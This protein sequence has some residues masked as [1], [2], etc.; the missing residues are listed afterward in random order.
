MFLIL[1]AR[2]LHHGQ[3]MKAW[4]AERATRMEVFYLSRY[5]PV[6]NPQECLN[7]DLKQ[8]MGKPVPVSAKACPM[9]RKTPSTAAARATGGRGRGEKAGQPGGGSI[10]RADPGPAPATLLTQSLV[11]R[12]P[13][14][15]R[16][17]F[18]RLRLNLAGCPGS[19]GAVP[20]CRPAEPGWGTWCAIRSA[21]SE[22]PCNPMRSPLPRLTG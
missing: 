21:G 14:A 10:S 22:S 20:A 17:G 4:L 6:L 15:R 8:A 19:S 13:A 16:I 5:S 12:R 1:E 9:P 11:L 7:A 2:R 18:G 3:P